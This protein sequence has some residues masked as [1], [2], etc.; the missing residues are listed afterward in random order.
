M[1]DLGFIFDKQSG[2]A[3]HL[4]RAVVSV[5]TNIAEGCKRDYEL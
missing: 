1:Q 3:V 4:R 2:L 5:P